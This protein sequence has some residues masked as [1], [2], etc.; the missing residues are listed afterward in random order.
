[1]EIWDNNTPPWRTYFLTEHWVLF[2]CGPPSNPSKISCHVDAS[3]I[4]RNWTYTETFLWNY[5]RITGHDRSELY[6]RINDPYELN[7]LAPANAKCVP[8]NIKSVIN[9]L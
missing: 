9:E 2:A 8:Q 5:S 3:I 6:D 1:M 4:T 7:N